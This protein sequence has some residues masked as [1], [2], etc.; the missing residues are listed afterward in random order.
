MN[1]SLTDK[2]VKEF[3]DLLSSK[4]AVPGGGGAAALGGA[5]GIGWD[6]FSVCV[7]AAG[8]PLGVLIVSLLYGGFRYGCISLQANIGT[9]IELND[10]V[11]CAIILFFSV[12]YI[13]P[14][15]DL[16]RFFRRKRV[17][18]EK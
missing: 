7:L 2:T 18:A 14:D 17:K 9:P 4:A 8:N 11:K 5:M 10:I 3:C 12:K 13:R 6:G 1:G 15:M 16:L